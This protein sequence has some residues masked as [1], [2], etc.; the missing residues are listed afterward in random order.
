MNGSRQSQFALAEHIAQGK[1]LACEEGL[2]AL[3]RLLLHGRVRS[4]AVQPN[5]IGLVPEPSHLALGVLPGFDLAFTYGLIE[6]ELAGE[7]LL[8][9]LVAERLE[10]FGLGREA[11]CE[12]GLGFFQQTAV[13]HGR[14]TLVEALVQQRSIGREAELQ[15]GEALKPI[16]LGR[17]NMSG[18]LAGQQG[19]L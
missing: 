16:T 13:K 18:G 4:E 8:R 14:R 15:N 5:Y 10:G 2:H 3:Q 6:R 12:E 17:L 11:G 7:N 19:Q 1:S 9:L